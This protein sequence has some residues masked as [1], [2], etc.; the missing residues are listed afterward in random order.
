MVEARKMVGNPHYEI[1]DIRFEH[2]RGGYMTVWFDIGGAAFAEPDAMKNMYVG[3]SDLLDNLLAGQSRF[4][5]TFS[6]V[7]AGHMAPAA[8]DWDAF[9]R[10]Y[11]DRCVDLRA[12]ERVRLG[13]MA[14]RRKRQNEAPDA[15][16]TD[17]AALSRE[18]AS[19]SWDDVAHAVIESLNDTA[20]RLYPEL[21][22]CSP[23]YNEQLREILESHGERLAN[24]LYALARSV[25]Q[26]RGN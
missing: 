15:P 2:E 4:S 20:V 16:A 25:R 13:W 8:L 19:P 24:Q 5:R 26:A 1:T 18:E 17:W 6:A 10:G 23:E 12:E 14:E 21:L 3:L 11:V 7:R 22:D 9:L